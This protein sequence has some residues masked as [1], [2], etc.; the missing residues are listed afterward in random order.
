MLIYDRALVICDNL[1]DHMFNV[2]IPVHLLDWQVCHSE[3]V[4]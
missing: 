1:V 3:L 2:T 4:M